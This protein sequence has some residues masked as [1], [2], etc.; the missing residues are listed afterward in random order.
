MPRIRPLLAL[1]ALF[2]V[3]QCG[4]PRDGP[5]DG[6]GPQ[7]KPWSSGKVVI[8]GFYVGTALKGGPEESIR[9]ANLDDH[10]VD[11]ADFSLSDVLGPS[12]G[13]HYMARGWGRRRDVVF[14][15][16]I[17]ETVLAPGQEIVIARDAQGYHDQFGER[18]D[19]E[20]GP[21]DYFPADDPTVPNLEAD[22]SAE[23]KRTAKSL[24]PIWPAAGGDLIILFG[25]PDIAGE[26]PVV[27]LVAYDFH[28]GED[29][30]LLLEELKEYERLHGMP[31]GAL[32]K[33]P[34]LDPWGA[35][36]MPYGVKTRVIAR[37]RD[38]DGRILPDTNSYAD[39]DASSSLQ[40]LGDDPTHRVE[41]AGQS[42]F[43]PVVTT[44]RA[45][46]T[47]TA[48]PDSNYQGLKE[49]WEAAQEEILVS[50]YYFKNHY[51]LETLVAAIERGVDVQ[52]FMEGTTVGVKNGFTDGE[53]YI[54]QQIEEAGRERSG[55]KTRG[56]GRVY[57]LRTDAKARIADR[58]W[59][60]HS[61]YSI[62]DRKK[63]VVGS[64]NYGMTGHP[65]DPTSG[66]RGWEIQI[67]T[68]PGE[69]PLDI[70][71]AL[72]AVWND[73]V[74][75]ENHRDVVRY[76]DTPETVEAK[77]GRGRYG[78]P[79]R[80]YDPTE[81]RVAPSGSYV[82]VLAHETIDEEATFELVL[83]PDNSLNETTG[84]LGAIAK[85]REE[86]LVQ[87][88]DLRLYGGS[89]IRS[90]ARTPET[91]PNL[92][93]EALV[94][95]ARRG[96]RVRVLLDCSKFM[97]QLTTDEADDR[98]RDNND[99]T[100][101]WLRELAE[102]E[103]LDIEARLIDNKTTDDRREDD[104]ETHGLSKIHNKG[105][106]IDGRVTLFSSI[107]GSENSFKGNRE[108]GVLVTSERV[109]AYYSYLF[110]YDWTTVAAPRALQGTAG[111]V[112]GGLCSEDGLRTGVDLE[113]LA[114]N[115]AYYFRVTAF[116]RDTTDRDPLQPELRYGP[117]ESAFSEEIALRTSRTG[118]VALTWEENVSERL[119]GDLAG[120]R[121]Y[122][123]A[124]SGAAASTPA[125][126]KKRH[127]YQ[128]LARRMGES[129]LEVNG[130]C[131]E[132]RE[133]RKKAPRRRRG[134]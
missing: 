39:W 6:P 13:D 69:A 28:S 98:K 134:R 4:P 114:P 17:E 2:L 20:Y 16:G 46:I 72:L 45:L 49:A 60:D 102:R 92:F 117:H 90:V 121:V 56:L 97:C 109:A 125:L 1:L 110:W 95:A 101:A 75:P 19:F 73:D 37:D 120:Y 29:Y 7:R 15:M 115:Q 103:G 99:D 100:V 107:N 5:I 24:W 79:P 51:L 126:A 131:R 11:L 58:Y 106:V 127:F 26:T 38:V 47:M 66:N 33:G 111:R 118:R 55:I 68:P 42:H 91:T 41:M 122:F 87:H 50:V 129:P 130:A 35:L 116:D 86:I 81:D 14:P 78:P 52:L 104:A 27:D 31:E 61:K 67:G 108:V 40:H 25:P 34:P 10:P 44:E 89:R 94:Y 48:A 123:G 57:W 124:A 22:A 12:A 80:D 64:E 132:P 84:I 105:L 74:D 8:S 36:A 96:V 93:L 85:A 43:P 113:G 128:A 54:A 63:I 70:V 112:P 3:V 65:V 53:R 62:I 32:W 119:E 9:I 77:T 88:L 76:T 30:P 133:P 23:A 21:D 59:F 83:S 82:P 18:P 71:Q